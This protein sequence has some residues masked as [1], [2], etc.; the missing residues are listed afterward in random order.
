MAHPNLN[1][2]IGFCSVLP[3]YSGSLSLRW[4]S[5]C[6]HDFQNEGCSD[7]V[8][9][10]RAHFFHGEGSVSSRKLGFRFEIA[11]YVSFLG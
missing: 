1:C 3:F 9:I 7:G 4:R 6:H 10:V 2:A 8:G 11:Q 5:T